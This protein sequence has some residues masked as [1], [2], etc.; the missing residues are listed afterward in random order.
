MPLL[1]KKAESNNRKNAVHQL[2]HSIY[3]PEKFKYSEKEYGKSKIIEINTGEGS[4]PLVYSFADG[5][6]LASSESLLVEQA[7]RQLASKGI[8]DNRFFRD[9]CN[10]DDSGEVSLF[11]NHNYFPG[12]MSNIMN[13]DSKGRIDEFGDP[14]KTNPRIQSEKFRD[15]ASWSSLNIFFNEDNLTLDGYSAADDSLNHYL[16]VFEGQQPA[17]FRA[18]EFLPQNISFFINISLS[19]KKVIF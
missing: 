18:D 15:Y 16:S 5:L 14:V 12:F 6:L 19:D 1:I 3:P 13:S 9:I 11:I 8:V 4:K 7:V 10:S 17:R 2:F